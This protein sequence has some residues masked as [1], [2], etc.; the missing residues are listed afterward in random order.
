M[1]WLNPSDAAAAAK[2]AVPILLFPPWVPPALRAPLLSATAKE[3]GGERVGERG[4]GRGIRAPT[5]QAA[6]DEESSPTPPSPS[7]S[8][9]SE[10]YPSGSLCCPNG[11]PS[12][13]P[14]HTASPPSPTPS[15]TAGA[16]TDGVSPPLQSHRPSPPPPALPAPSL[17]EREGEGEGEVERATAARRR[18]A[19]P[20][21]SGDGGVAPPWLENIVS[22]MH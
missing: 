17:G 19:S 14:G 3:T 13:K 6:A 2:S 20:K 16:S 18:T 10:G 15:P 8:E 11:S 21:S 4:L 12:S 1:C 7:F 22:R 5:P 9:Q